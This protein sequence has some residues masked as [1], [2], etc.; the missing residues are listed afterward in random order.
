MVLL[1]LLPSIVIVILMSVGVG[2]AF[3][4]ILSPAVGFR[5]FLVGIALAFLST[6]GLTGAAAFA[7]AGGRAWRVT[8][9]H[10]AL[11]PLLVTVP[12]TITLLV[13]DRSQEAGSE[14]A[15]PFRMAGPPEEVFAHALAVAQAM[16][17]WEVTRA[18]AVRLSI[19]AVTR[20]AVFRFED[21]VVI[22]IIP[23][24]QGSR[25][26]IRSRLDPGD[27]GRGSGAAR[28]PVLE[29]RFRSRLSESVR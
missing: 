25:L 4:E 19:E 21:P 14:D 5:L 26:E 10:A 29:E 24:A 18:D 20:S 13:Q 7:S 12:V 8:A 22:R 27:G 23:E 1:W 17:G 6:V 28:M 15:E 16:K 2:G 11:V 9:L 3:T